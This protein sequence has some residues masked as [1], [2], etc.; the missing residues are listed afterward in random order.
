M[1]YEAELVIL[2]LLGLVCECYVICRVEEGD[3]SKWMGSDGMAHPHAF[4]D[5]ELGISVV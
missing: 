3:R 2:S 4:F 1:H 5:W